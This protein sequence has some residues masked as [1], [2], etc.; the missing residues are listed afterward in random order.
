MNKLVLFGAGKIGRSFIGQLFAASGYEVVFI[1]ISERIIDELNRRKGY[2][3]IIKGHLK[4]EV[5][6]VGNVR[7]V[8]AILED[9]VAEEIADCDI[10]AVSVGQQGLPGVIRLLAKGLDLRYRRSGLKPLDII[11]AENMRNTDQYVRDLLT[12]IMDKDF[13]VNEMT[14]LIETSIGKMVP[15]LPMEVQANDP[16][17]VYAEKYNTLI[18]DKKAFKSPIPDVAGLAPKENIKAWVD[19]KSYIHNFG[20]SAAAYTGSVLAPEK[21]CMYEILSIREVHEF[22]RSAMLQSAGILMNKY[23]GEFTSDAL[24]EHSDDLI[25]RF[26]NRSLGDTVFRVGCDL[27]RKLHRNDRVLSPLIDGV[28]AALPA[29]KILQT[30]FRGLRFSGKDEQGRMFPGDTEFLEELKREGLKFV[31]QDLCGLKPDQDR[32]IIEL[33]CNNITGSGLRS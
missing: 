18:L 31:L 19:R 11:L 28:K 16:L 15:I 32:H 33:I 27:K 6:L 25:S 24:A 8:L 21:I 13:P 17:L 30:F 2:K 1:D 26:M 3:V 7:G 20:H 10:A 14:G 4:D 22:T 29:D 12:G 9:R 5:I 23:P